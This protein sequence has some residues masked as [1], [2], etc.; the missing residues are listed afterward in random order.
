MNIVLYG[1]GNRMQKLHNIL[2]NK[3]LSFLKKLQ[4]NIPEAEFFLVGGIVRD[5]ILGRPSKDYDLVVRKV[6]INKL[7]KS[8]SSLGQVNLVGK[9]FGVLKFQPK[10]TKLPEPIDIAL[11]R[12][13]HSWQTGGYRDFDIQS[14]PQLPIAKDLERRDFTINAL[15]Y[16]INDRKLVDLFNGQKDIKKKTIRTVGQPN[17]I[18]KEDYSRLLRAIRFACQLNFDIDTATWGSIK[19]QIKFINK[20]MDGDYVVPREVIAQEMVKSFSASPTLALDLYDKSQAVAL[21]MPDMLKMKGCPQPTEFHAE[22]DVWQHTQLCLKNL[23]S[24]KFKNN[25]GAKKLSP[26]L[27]FSLMW[28]DLGKPSTM[29][30]MDRLRYNNHDN[31]GADLAQDIMKRLK[32]SSAGLDTDSVA[33]LIRRHMIAAYTKKSPMKNTTVEK[34]FYNEQWPGQDLLKLIF[35]DVQATVP[36]NGRPDFSSYQVIAKQVA[37]LKNVSPLKKS[38]PKIIINGHEVMKHLKIKAG[39]KIGKLLELLREEQ[40]GGN[41][42]SKSQALK[43][44]KDNKK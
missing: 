26:E 10:N 41:I 22:G 27:I 16:N 31:V 28:H 33:W 18:F 35:A 42:K 14:D 19:T 1:K 7:Q 32:L 40:L 5:T 36:T 30:K 6:T 13:E 8:L 3:E 9:N 2:L 44:I 37:D 34:Y 23:S 43:F 15:A 24:S 17:K 38:L 29:K 25:F 20:K 11:P 21:L 4:K 12:T 39:P